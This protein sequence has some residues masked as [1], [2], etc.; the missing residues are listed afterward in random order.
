MCTSATVFKIFI[1][2]A[3][4]EWSRKC[5]RMG[6]KTEDNFYVH[7]FL[8]ADYETVIPRGVGDTNYTGRKLEEENE[9]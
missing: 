9:N 2:T 7:S 3:L 1:D 8:F 5:K 6:L 4:K